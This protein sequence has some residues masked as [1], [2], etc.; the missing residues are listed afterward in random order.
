MKK[1]TARRSTAI[2]QTEY[3]GRQGMNTPAAL[4]ERISIYWEK[5]FSTEVKIAALRAGV[6][7][8][9]YVRQATEARM[10]KEK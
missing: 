10:A 2:T 8:S 1:T 5:K 6:R 9:E 4:H 3:H 7:I